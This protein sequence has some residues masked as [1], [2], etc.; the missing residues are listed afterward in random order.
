MV[1]G[2]YFDFTDAPELHMPRTGNA[3]ST[4]CVKMLSS[5]ALFESYTLKRPWVPLSGQEGRY[6]SKTPFEEAD[7]HFSWGLE[8]K[9]VLTLLWQ[10][11]NK[12]IF[13]AKGRHY[14]PSR[15]QFW[16]FHTF[17]PLV[18]QLSK[19]YHLLHVGAVELEGKPVLF[20]A[21]SFGGKSTLTDYFIQ[22][23]HPLIS[24][25]SLAVKKQNGQFTVIPSYPF[26][27]PYREPESLGH[28]AAFFAQEAKP[29]YA[30][31]ILEKA[32][33][34]ANVTVIELKGIEKFK[35][36][37]ES[38][39]I[40]FPFLKKEYFVFFSD[41]AQS[42]PVYRIGIPWD[43]TKLE[44]VYQKINTLIKGGESTF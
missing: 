8:I 40:D 6:F 1:H 17:F 43:I 39:F 14:T 21:P 42:V 37:K 33:E 13:Y 11:D 44:E 38:A 27:R 10:P 31:F 41:L 16:I 2:H 35:A 23:R 25:D 19:H 20:S 9:D 12:T 18:M 36:I 4:I 28:K 22:K 7:E 30:V 3:D 26:H 5:P 15:L 29:L 24:D 32:D 34:D